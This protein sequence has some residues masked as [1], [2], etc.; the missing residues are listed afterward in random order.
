TAISHYAGTVSGAPNFAFELCVE[1]I[2]EAEKQHID[3]SSWRVAFNGS[4]PVRARTLDRFADAFSC[5]GFK[6]EAL[7]PCYGM[8]EATLMISVKKSSLPIYREAAEA[9]LAE[10]RIESP[11]REE[12]TQTFVSSGSVL[13]EMEVAIIDPASRIVCPSGKVGEIWVRGAS[14]G[15]GYWG[16]AEETE[17]VFR[18][19]MASPE[20]KQFLRTGDLGFIE[21]GELFVTGRL[22]DLI[23]IRGA[24]HYPQ[25]IEEIVGKCHP[26]LVAGGSAAFSVVVEP[27]EQL[28]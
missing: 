5:C 23:I 12:K 22:K 8:A 11:E 28:G 26:A 13:P 16:N 14:I 3:L 19:V 20:K 15:K 27:E 21:N 6:P 9:A 24:N 17:R 10:N 7:H 25:D 4:E 2:T 18:A 1:K